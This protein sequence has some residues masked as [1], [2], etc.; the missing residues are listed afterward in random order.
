M[1]P[2][3]DEHRYFVVFLSPHGCHLIYVVGT[4]YVRKPERLEALAYVVPLAAFVRAIIERRARR[5][6]E[7]TG[8][9]L[10]LPGKRNSTRPTARMVP[11]SFDPITVVMTSDGIRA[12]AES[13]L[14][15]DKMF[16][17]L[18]VS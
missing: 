3:R 14:C 5:Y 9:E 10:P 7:A 11:D 6:A 1:A 8:K 16:K 13:P 2:C 12:P 15:P 18:G 4:M 17:A